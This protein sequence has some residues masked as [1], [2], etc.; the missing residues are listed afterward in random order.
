M[1]HFFLYTLFVLIP[2]SV[3]SQTRVIDSLYTVERT[4]N[5]IR[6][7]VNILH[8]IVSVTWDYDFDKARIAAER[9]LALARQTGDSE[10]LVI[11]LTDVG[12]YYYFMG[13]Y[14]RS[15]QFY[16]QALQ[17]GGSKNFGEYPAYTL[18]RLANLHRV[19]GSFDSATYYYDKTQESLQHVPPGIAQA[20][21]YFHRGWMLYDLS[22]FEKALPFLYK[23]RSIRNAIGDS[24]LI[25]ECWRVI[26]TVHL[27]MNHYDSAEHYLTKTLG[28]AERFKDTE[29]II[30]TEINRGELFQAQSQVLSTIK[31]Y[32]RALELL[33]TH[34]FKRYHAFA[35]Y[36][37]GQVFEDQ[38]NYQKAIEYYLN[39]LTMQ[40]EIN[41]RQEMARIQWRLG[42]TY[43]ALNNYDLS[44]M[45]ADKSL[46]LMKTINDRAGI[47][48]A[49]NLKGRIA[50]SQKQL[51]RA[52]VYYDSALYLRKQLGLPVYISNTLSNI[53][54]IY[55]QK[56]QFIEAIV[57]LKQN[58]E[59]SEKL[60]DEET[61]AMALN[62]LGLTYGRKGDFQNALASLK[63]AED[64]VNRLGKL[65]A[66][67]E[68]NLN[69]ARVYSGMKRPDMA[70]IHY[71]RYIEIDEN[72]RVRQNAMAVLELNA[73]YQVEEKEKQIQLLSNENQLK[74]TQISVQQAELRYKNLI[75]IFSVAG[76]LILL[77]GGFIL[78]QYY[79]QKS[80]AHEELMTLH[81]EIQ[82]KKEEIEAQAEEL[83]EAND[84]LSKLNNELIEKQE[85][86]AAQSE[87]LREANATITEINQGLERII[88][89]RTFQLTEAYKELDTFFYR[90][91]HDFRR[92]LTTFLGL[93]EVAK[94]TIKDTNALELFEKVKETA[95]N[96][97]KMLFKLQ[98]ISN[99]G[100]QQLIYKEVFIR[101]IC[102]NIFD[103]Y[104]EELARKN[105]L[106]KCQVS[107]RDAFYSYPAMV[108]L[109]LENLVEN[110]INFAMKEN[111]FITITV[112]ERDQHVVIE[113]E[114]NGEGIDPKYQDRIFEMYFRGNEKSKGN[115]LGLY[116][117]KKAVEKLNGTIYFTSDLGKG[118]IFTVVLPFAS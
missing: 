9:E 114:D 40:Q 7:K 115:G 73:L 44:S 54:T 13:D 102:S 89:A 101:E 42:W 46:Q 118:V 57:Y 21:L 30:L 2:L 23:A 95:T 16:R 28:L 93:A 24:L 36:K 103:S 79:Q 52:L 63:R 48:L 32:D 106:T 74:E 83:I 37:I 50:A 77:T 5:D 10:S 8:R 35:L 88:E 68:N 82:E 19:Q 14:K 98:S 104:R 56:G 65:Y 112:F 59:L 71:E 100:A 33:T 78:F 61:Q 1:R 72:M 45:Y 49:Y 96:L 67:R 41:G 6:E 85:E 90:S 25:A 4:T 3:Y 87:E 11:A 12:M 62:A 92:P 105:I 64:I 75:L 70:A 34:P 116:I 15:E 91:S 108:S 39:A 18:T 58:L 84:A 76:I 55:Q 60:G 111:P 110:S 47:S 81:H 43:N 29:L 66:Q 117:V 86:I 113:V 99:V 94:V 20:S 80:K 38:E 26:G 22:E 107:L 97:D 27:G 53:A 69:Y 31:S 51:D 109:I 17:A